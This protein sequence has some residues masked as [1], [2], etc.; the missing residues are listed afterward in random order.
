M[1]KRAV[2]PLLLVL[3]VCLGTVSSVH[4]AVPPGVERNGF[5]FGPAT[6]SDGV[7]RT[8]LHRRGASTW[9]TDDGSQWKLLLLTVGG[10]TLFD[11]GNSL[12]LD[13]V[14]DCAVGDEVSTIGLVRE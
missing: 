6:C 1:T 14:V 8:F 13:A 9:S 10:V 5:V 3:G 7:T 2:V 11:A 4:A 12:G